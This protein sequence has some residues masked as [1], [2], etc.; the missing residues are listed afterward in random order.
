MASSAGVLDSA[1]FAREEDDT[2]SS[3][4]ADPGAAP[5][6][7]SGFFSFNWASK[8]STRFSRASSTSVL[9]P[10]FFG[11]ASNHRVLLVSRAARC[12]H[13]WSS[14]PR[15]RQRIPRIV[16]RPG[17]QLQS[18]KGMSV[19]YMHGHWKTV[20]ASQ[21]GR[22]RLHLI[23]TTSRLSQKTSSTHEHTMP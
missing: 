9:G 16:C 4:A 3:L 12:L 23:C 5:S 14:G 18:G 15:T 7:G 6:S 20:Q 11:T 17:I 10:L 1:F 8:P 22:S 13:I 2:A 21:A 19:P